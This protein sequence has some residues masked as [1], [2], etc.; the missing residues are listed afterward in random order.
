MSWYIK[1]GNVKFGHSE[2]FQ[3][4][5]NNEMELAAAVYALAA[6]GTY[7]ALGFQPPDV[8]CD[9]AYAI[10][11][12]TIWKNSWKANGWKKS[13][14]KSPENL[15]L[16]KIYDK[17]EEKGFEIK[18]KKINGHSGI[19]GNEIADLLATGKMTEQEVMKKYG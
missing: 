1:T 8:Y 18:L 6:A 12:L 4:T 17:I 2:Q 11:T 5:T 16:I 19:L 10:N 9:S 13:D 15:K 14:N 7:T 3:K